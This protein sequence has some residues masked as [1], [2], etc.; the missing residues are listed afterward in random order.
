MCCGRIDGPACLHRT[1]WATAGDL[2]TR[3]LR[4]Y[5][6]G[7]MVSGNRRCRDAGAPTSPCLLQIC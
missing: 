4:Y 5:G 2:G 3:G 6:W 7:A 1:E